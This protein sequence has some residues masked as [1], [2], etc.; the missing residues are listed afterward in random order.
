MSKTGLYHEVRGNGP[1]VL[2]I[3]GATGDAGQF[4]QSA[5]RLAD[6]FTVL[7]YDRRGNSRS[8]V[9]GDPVAAATMTAQA[10]DAASIIRECG[11]E[12]AVVCG[13]SGGAIITLELLARDP[14]AVKGAIVHEPPLITLLPHSNDPS[15]LQPILDL[16]AQDP[17]AALELFLRANAGDAGWESVD[18]ATRER[19]LGNAEALFEREVGQFIGYRP[20]EDVL[21]SLPMP[22]TLLHSR[23]G[24][25]Y[26]P[27]IMGWLE[28][29]T[30]LEAGVLTGGHAPYLDM[31]QV[32]AEELRPILRQLAAN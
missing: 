22:V 1:A 15:P 9:D 3:A 17:R 13:T 6:E 14:R 27:V 19:M 30:G 11:F 18:P 16:Y 26:A 10:A 24:L 28:A 29:Q 20:D 7:T 32:F 4:A 21:R 23:D 25:D 2:F 12:E 8:R 5:D 31:P